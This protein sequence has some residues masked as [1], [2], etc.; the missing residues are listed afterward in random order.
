MNKTIVKRISNIISIVFTVLIVLFTATIVYFTFFGQKDEDGTTIIFDKQVRIVTTNS[1]AKS[2]L[3]D[4]SEYDIKSIPVNSIVFIELVP[5]DKNEAYEWYDGLE[6]GD[7]LTFKYV[8][9]SQVVITHRLIKKEKMNDGNFKLYLEGDNKNSNV[10]LLTQV[11]DTSTPETGNYVIGKVT[12]KSL[13]IGYILTL[14]KNPKTLIFVII[15]L[16]IIIV[17]INRIK[18]ALKYVDEEPTKEKNIDD[19]LKDLKEKIKR[20]EE[21]E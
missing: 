11:I 3:T 17:C 5:S 1:M 15:L 12:G 20:L 7:V 14:L 18:K 10:N 4:L 9:D 16:V 2:E 8:Y 13:I 19:E 21:Q 6:V